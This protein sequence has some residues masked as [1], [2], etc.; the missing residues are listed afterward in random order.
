[1]SS[2]DLTFLKKFDKIKGAD[3]S[4]CPVKSYIITEKILDE[5]LGVFPW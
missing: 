4:A 3:I 1:L 5:N 2:A